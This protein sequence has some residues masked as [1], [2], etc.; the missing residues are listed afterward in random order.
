M[1]EES[2]NRHILQQ[3][4]HSRTLLDKEQYLQALPILDDLIIR[5]DSTTFRQLRATLREIVNDLTGSL[6]D[7]MHKNGTPD[8]VLLEARLL[9]KL[10]FG[11][12]A[13]SRLRSV[14]LSKK[15][16]EE[17]KL[18]AS[19]LGLAGRRF[20][21]ELL[22]LNPICNKEAPNLN[23]RRKSCAIEHI[24]AL[25]EFDACLELF[26]N[27]NKES[28]SVLAMCD[29]LRKIDMLNET[30]PIFSLTTIKTIVGGIRGW[31]SFDEASLLASLA[32]KVPAG[33]CIVEIGSFQGRSTCAI[34]AGAKLGSNN[35][36]HAV[37]TFLG[38][39][40]I[41]NEN[42]LPIFQENL[43]SR[44]LDGVVTV[45]KDASINVAGNWNNQNI[46]L[47]FIDA[48]HSYESVKSDFENWEK[49][50]SPNGLIAFH[51]SHQEG[52]NKLLLEII[53]NKTKKVRVI[54]LRDS[55]TDLP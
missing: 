55:I 25:G 46:G 23:R 15:S 4:R 50:V 32:S 27:E 31:L 7:I 39:Q 47:L 16:D 8:N 13:V 18:A 44:G 40:G 49:W 36:V 48:N 52:P 19:A 28:F 29:Q 43:K 37:D 5:Q 10:G 20:D 53:Q 17:K 9:A 35:V 38:L 45:H 41:F 2:K 22:G 33:K 12:E 21:L 42:T 54:G 51:D 34:A 1:I 30:N 11:E 26:A 6:S 24:V 14:L 3:L